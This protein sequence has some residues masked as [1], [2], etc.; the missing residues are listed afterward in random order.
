MT[1]APAQVTAVIPVWGAY[2]DDRLDEA[3]ASLLSQDVPVEILLVDNAHVPPLRRPGTTVVRSEQ[4]LPLGAARNLGL[5]AVRTPLVL[6]WDADDVMPRAALRRLVEEM[7]RDRGLVAC[8]AAIIDARSGEP[9][10]W[11]RRWPLALRRMHRV[12][13]VVNAVSSLFPVTGAVLRTGMARDARFP[14][15]SGGDDWVMG[16][17]LAFRGRVALLPEPGR[18]YRRHPDSVS[19]SWGRR[20]ALLHARIV[21]ERLRADPAV[22]AIVPRL[23]GAIRLAQ[24]TVIGLLSPISRLTPRR[25]RERP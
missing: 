5:D 18:V 1:D 4:R 17:S 23:E 6:F 25:R 8:A 22:P 21:R 14:E 9:H 7:D 10:H 20:E 3:V 2:A 24:L 12:F 19:A 16:V 13:A 15:V 11:P